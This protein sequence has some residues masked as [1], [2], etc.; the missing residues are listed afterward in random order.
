[1]DPMSTCLTGSSARGIP[2]C[3]GLYAPATGELILTGAAWAVEEGSWS[4]PLGRGAQRCVLCLPPG[5][6]RRVKPQLSTVITGLITGPWMAPL[7]LLH[8]PSH[9]LLPGLMTCFVSCLSVCFLG[10]PYQEISLEQSLAQYP[11]YLLK[12]SYISSN[13]FAG[14]KIG[15]DEWQGEGRKEQ[16]MKLPVF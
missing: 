13:A 8:F 9:L 16:F 15:I 12:S 3:Q 5:F 7:C 1:M 14:V 11:C 6:F 4:P 2:S 10:T